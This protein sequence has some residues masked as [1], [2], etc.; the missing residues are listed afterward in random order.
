M[1]GV[2]PGGFRG[3]GPHFMSYDVLDDEDKQLF[4]I[5]FKVLYSHFDYSASSLTINDLLIRKYALGWKTRLDGF[6][7]G[8]FELFT[9]VTVF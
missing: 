6:R 8:N 1:F 2:D 5:A 7:S 3:D 4:N 9:H